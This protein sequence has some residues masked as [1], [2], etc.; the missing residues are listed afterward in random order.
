[1]TMEFG[2]SGLN[3]LRERILSNTFLEKARMNPEAFTRTRKMGAREL[4]YYC[5]NKKGLCTNMETNN[6][7]EKIGKD[8]GICAQSLFDQR[9]KLS[10]LVFGDL[11][12]SYLNLFN[13]KYSDDARLFKGYANCLKKVC[14]QV[15]LY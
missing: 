12:D 6:F 8:E 10:P 7:F 9:K 2:V 15:F 13:S 14:L 5:L 11:N 3:L 1:M 4:V